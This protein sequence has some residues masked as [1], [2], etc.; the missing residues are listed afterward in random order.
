MERKWKSDRQVAVHTFSRI[1]IT[2]LL[3]RWWMRCEERFVPINYE[4]GW[5]N[6]TQI[7][8]CQ[9]DA[10]KMIR[11]EWARMMLATKENFDDVI[12]TDESTFEVEYHSTKCYRRIGQ[13]R[14]LKSWP[15]HL[16]KIHACGG[17]SKKGATSLILFKD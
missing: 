10:N 16:D 5:L 7:F 14:I 2:N 12:F 3:I 17:I 9:R 6:A 8:T 11:L 4:I 1:F 15:K 13:P